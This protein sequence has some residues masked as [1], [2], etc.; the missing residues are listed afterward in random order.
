MDGCKKLGCVEAADCVTHEIAHG[1]QVG[2]AWRIGFDHVR[3]FS[4][5]EKAFKNAAIDASE[6]SKIFGAY[7]FIDFVDAVIDRAEFDQLR[8]DVGDETPV[9][10]AAAGGKL[11]ADAQMFKN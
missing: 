11:G 2:A 5:V 7:V 1:A 9:R 6:S 4:G 3:R 8:T 10:G